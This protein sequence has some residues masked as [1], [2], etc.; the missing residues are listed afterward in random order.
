MLI[1]IPV[2]GFEIF[3]LSVPKICLY[4]S[5]IY[6]T[7]FESVMVTNTVTKS[8]CLLSNILMFMKTS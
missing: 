3:F 5:P 2:D 7:I 8:S 4:I 6:Y 1:F